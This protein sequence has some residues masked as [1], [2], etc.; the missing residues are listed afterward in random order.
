M[1]GE[2]KKK[3]ILRKMNTQGIHNWKFKLSKVHTGICAAV[4][5]YRNDKCCLCRIIV[6]KMQLKIKK[7]AGNPRKVQWRTAVTVSNEEFAINVQMFCAAVPQ[8]AC[9]RHWLQSSW[10]LWTEMNR[11]MFDVSDSLE[12]KTSKLVW[13]LCHS[14]WTLFGLVDMR[15]IQRNRSYSHWWWISY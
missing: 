9:R 3:N 14:E 11:E 2:R 4:S 5:I 15:H 8:S 12:H 13:F 1:V 6:S 10:R 7:N